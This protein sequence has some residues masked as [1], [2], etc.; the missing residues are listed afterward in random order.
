MAVQVFSR[1]ITGRDSKFYHQ[2]LNATT[3][4]RYETE[5][6]V[7]YSCLPMPGNPYPA[8]LR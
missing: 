4:V 2:K 7:R 8:F 5:K 1:V 6:H 3:Y